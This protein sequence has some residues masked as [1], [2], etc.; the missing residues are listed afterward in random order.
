MTSLDWIIIFV[1]LCGI[2]L[3]GLY[4]GRR[5]ETTEDYFLGGRAIPWWAATLSMVATEISAATFLGAPEQG[6]TRDLTYLQFGIGSILARFV[7]AFLFIGIFYRLGVFTVYGFLGFRFGFPT[8]ASAAGA[9]LLGRLFAGGSRLF[10]ASLA[11]KVITGYSMTM[12]IMVLGSIAIGYTLF[13]GIKAVIWTDVIQGIILI[14]AAVLSVNSLLNAIPLDGG[15]I[16]AYLQENAKLRL[17]DTSVY[18]DSGGR[19]LFSNAYHFI[20]AVLGGFF[21]TMATHGTDQS[22]IQRMLTCRDSLQGKWSMVLSGF[23][24][25]GVT[26]IFMLVGL[27]LFVYVGTS[28]DDPALVTLAH[29]LAD[30]GK[31]GDFFLYYIMMGLPDGITGIIIAAVIAAAMSSIDSELNAMSSAVV[32]DFYK[33]L[34]NPEGDEDTF[35]NMARVGTLICGVFLVGAALAIARYYDQNP[36]TDLL[37]IA[38]GVM[39][40]FYGGLLGIFLVGLLTRARGNNHTCIAGLLFSTLAI[41]LVS[42]KAKLLPLLGLYDPILDSGPLAWLYHFKLAWPWFIIIGTGVSFFVAILGMT[43]EKVVERYQE[44]I[45]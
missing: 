45:F 15:E 11:V 5:E 40:L 37:S 25:I 8:R 23:L 31:N 42:Y 26:G 29:D 44:E 34:F 13:G 30:K 24:G 1:Y 17:F 6:Y 10:I 12:S 9:F 21:L 3:M 32:N 4:M 41:V 7:L 35:L 16:M 27:L 39:T 43:L 2:I 38:L 18:D 33:P 22:M 19:A 36:H 14:L 20:P 28:G